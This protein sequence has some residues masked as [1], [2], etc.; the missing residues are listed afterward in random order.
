MTAQAPPRAV[1]ATLDRAHVPYTMLQ[2]DRT[3]TAL[4]EARSLHVAPW[5]VAKTVVLVTPS[6][7][8]ARAVIPASCRLDLTKARSVLG[9]DS[10]RLATEDELA[11]RYPEFELGAVPPIGSTGDRVVVDIRLCGCDRV[12]F[13]AGT[14]ECSVELDTRSFLDVSDAEIADVCEEE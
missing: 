6:G 14:H 3:E 12:L 13:E 11:G 4:Q 1:T 5:Q 7:G 2:H 8:F 9:A 10:V